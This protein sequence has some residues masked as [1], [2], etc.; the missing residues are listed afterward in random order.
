MINLLL[1]LFFVACASLA[2][3]MVVDNPGRVTML[4][5]D[6]QIETSVAFIILVILLAAIFI[7]LFTLIIRLIIAS[8]SQFW[9]R[10]NVKQ[11]NNGITELTYSIAALASSN[12]TAAE[13]H[14]HKV[15]KLLGKTPLT[16]L[17]SAQIAKNKGNDA[18][19]H[20]L[21]EQLLGY[22]ETEYL[23][24]RSLSE[25]ASQNANLPKALQLAKKALELNPKDS[26]A[27]IAVASLQIRLKLWDEAISNIQRTKLPRKEKSRLLALT[28]LARGEL[29]MAGGYY[30]E[31]LSLVKTIISNLPDFPPAIAFC[32]NI[33]DKNQMSKKAA[34]LRIKLSQYMADGTWSCK[35]C[36]HNNKIWTIH[37]DSCGGFDTMELKY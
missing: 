13:T 34:K 19:T 15:E 6:Y 12:I 2:I 7:V 8:P 36:A 16:I 5:F 18:A 29:L 32:A 26:S 1:F 33:Y 21:L 9:Q 14:V 23:A 22:K 3:A 20:A 11:L 10:R 37:C 25:S 17:L 28:H 24:A 4:W 27:T 35:T 30:E 31:A